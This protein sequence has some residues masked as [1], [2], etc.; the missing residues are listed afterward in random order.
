VCIT[1]A[2]YK[3]GYINKEQNK[4]ENK[5][6]IIIIRRRRRRRII[7]IRTLELTI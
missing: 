3:K 4:L 1:K 6:I 5:I 7:R 2:I